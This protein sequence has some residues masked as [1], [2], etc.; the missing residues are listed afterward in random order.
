MI[1]VNK[2]LLSGTPDDVRWKVEELA[3][4]QGEQ[5]YLA[6]SWFRELAVKLA[7][8]NGL[9]VSAVSYDDTTVQELE[10]TLAEAPHLD[11]V[12]ID[13]SQ[14]G[15]YCQITLERWLPISGEHGIEDA[16][17]IIRSILTASAPPGAAG[18]SGVRLAP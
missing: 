7:T 9:V 17:K 15:D 3:C 13:R 5:E 8:S 4:D 11:G 10:V 6:G 2:Q 18:T 16:V 1:T 12:V 14:L